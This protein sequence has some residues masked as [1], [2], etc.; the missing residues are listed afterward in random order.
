MK[1][2]IEQHFCYSSDF[3]F[4][5][6]IVFLKTVLAGNSEIKVSKL[7]RELVSKLRNNKVN[8]RVNEKKLVQ[9]SNPYFVLKRKIQLKEKF[10][11]AINKYVIDAEVE[12]L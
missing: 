5:I 2:E 6:K 3:I 8:K 9:P 10:K 1:Y 7:L 11:I 4:G 12:K